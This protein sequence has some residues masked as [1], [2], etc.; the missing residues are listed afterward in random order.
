MQHFI[1]KSFFFKMLCNMNEKLK[2]CLQIMDEKLHFEFNFF[3]KIGHN[4]D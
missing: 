4:T 3:L 1:I 2:K